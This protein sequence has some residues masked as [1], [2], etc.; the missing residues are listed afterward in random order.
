L[1]RIGAVPESSQDGWLKSEEVI[2][3][4]EQYQIDLSPRSE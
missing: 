3:N 4:P 2:V 1:S